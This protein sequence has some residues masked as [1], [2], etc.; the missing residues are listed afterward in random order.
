MTI[1]GIQIAAVLEFTAEKSLS[2]PAGSGIE[3]QDR[4]ISFPV[5][6]FELMNRL[7]VRDIPVIHQLNIILDQ[8]YLS[9][10]N[11]VSIMSGQMGMVPYHISKRYFGRVRMIDR[12]G[13]ADRTFTNC[14]ITSDLKKTTFGLVVGYKFYFDNSKSIEDTC[15]IARPDIIFDIRLRHAELFRQNGYTVMYS[16]SGQMNS[17]FERAYI[18]DE[19]I[20]V[21]DDLVP[22]LGGIEPVHLDAKSLLKS[23]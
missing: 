19:F 5:S 6:H 17:G 2:L 12:L 14:E 13:L 3:L 10:D 1:I 18:D 23:K 22:A 4:F 11:E 15:R 9:K 21:R 16:Q 8:L 20:A 7:N